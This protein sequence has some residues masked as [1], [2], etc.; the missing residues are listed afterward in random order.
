MSRPRRAVVALTTTVLAAS[1]VVMSP[2]PAVAATSPSV[3]ACLVLKP[4]L[5]EGV[6]GQSGCV[7][8]L[9]GFLNK[10]VA[11]KLAIDGDF[12]HNTKWA[13]VLYQREH[14]LKTDGVVGTETWISIA[15]YCRSVDW[16]YCRASF[17]Y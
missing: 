14:Y 8:A 5:R 4:V 7:A 12:G 6:R 15:A 11:P 1:G 10:F 13:V 17:S 2:L 16:Y 9:Q 3:E